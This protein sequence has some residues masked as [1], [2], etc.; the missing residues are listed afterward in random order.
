MKNLSYSKIWLFIF[1]IAFSPTGIF[2][3]DVLE[4]TPNFTPSPRGAVDWFYTRPNF[5]DTKLPPEQKALLAPLPE[6][7]T[8]HES[9]LKQKNTGIARLQPQGRYAIT[10]RTVSVHETV[11]MRLPILG[12]AA[13]YSFTEK[14][15]KLGPWSDLYLA[16]NRFYAAVTGKTMGVLSDQDNVALGNDGHGLYTVR[17]RYAVGALT[18]LGDIPLASVTLSTPGVVFLTKLSPP[19]NYV[20]F[21]QLTEDLAQGL[22]VGDF[23]YR[24]VSEVKPDTTYLFRSILYKRDGAVVEPNEPYHRFKRLYNLAYD[25][26]DVLVAFRVIRIHENGSVTILW[27]KLQSFGASTIKGNAQKYTYND[28]KQLLKQ[29]LIK[30]M[31][32]TEVIAFLDVN[33]IEHLDYVETSEVRNNRSENSGIIDA[34]IPE[35][36]RIIDARFE[37]RIRF[38][39]NEKRQLVSWTMKKIRM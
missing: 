10:G 11:K 37:L 28:I 35:I 26:S 27:K 34:S 21:V 32:I 16:N 13:Y 9:F 18:Q 33:K 19:K 36:E 22:T 5:Y 30:G 2:G 14:T 8:A 3:Q 20:G 12:G 24:F 23:T 1:L 39:F 17:S 38:S 25:G 29:Q 31:T 15:N 4:V 7:Q 6:D